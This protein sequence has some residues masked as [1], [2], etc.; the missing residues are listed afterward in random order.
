[1]IIGA[2]INLSIIRHAELVSAS[3]AT[4]TLEQQGRKAIL[5][6]VQDDEKREYLS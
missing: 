5:T 2:H 4:M 3:P 6:Q 1:M